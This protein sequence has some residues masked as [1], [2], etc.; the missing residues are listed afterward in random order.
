ME[1]NERVTRE[2]VMARSMGRCELC[3]AVRDAMSM[4]HRMNRSQG[5]LWL[6]SNVPRLCGTGT[7][8]CHGWVTHERDLAKDAG[9]AILTGE[10]PASVPVWL[11]T[12]QFGPGWW[13][14]DDEGMVAFA[15]DA[16]APVL[17]EWATAA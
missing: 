9:L 1:P 15:D 13:T 12:A 5:G 2:L 3:G 16:P 17:P 6:P 11:R 10:H 4:H 7:T 14:L 8:Y